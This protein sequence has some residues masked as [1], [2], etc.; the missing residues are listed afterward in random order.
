[1]VSVVVCV[2]VSVVVSASDNGTLFTITEQ[3]AVAPSAVVTV[4][5]LVPTFLQFMLQ[6]S[7]SKPI[8]STLLVPTISITSVLLLSHI[9]PDL[10]SE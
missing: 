4:I 1:V 2:E 7:V 9:I 8:S 5:T 10:S 6:K 3:L